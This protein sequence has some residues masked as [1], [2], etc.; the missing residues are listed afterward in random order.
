MEFEN[1]EIGLFIG[2]DG[3]NSLEQDLDK[4]KFEELTALIKLSR[5]LQK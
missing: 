5:G 1:I 2:F 4:A 3:E